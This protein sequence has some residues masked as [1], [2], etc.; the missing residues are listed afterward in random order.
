MVAIV[1]HYPQLKKLQLDHKILY[2]LFP[3]L[4]PLRLFSQLIKV[5]SRV[6]QKLLKYF[7]GIII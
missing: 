1:S 4:F 3:M 5:I 7:Q 2:Q 6:F